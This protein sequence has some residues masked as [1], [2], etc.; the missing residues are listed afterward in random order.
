MTPGIPPI[1]RAPSKERGIPLTVNIP[2]H[3]GSL[4]PLPMSPVIAPNGHL[5]EGPLDDSDE[6]VSTPRLDK[7]KQ[8]AKEE[9][10]KPTPVLRRPS[11]ALDSEDEFLE[12][13]V[14]PEAV[15]SPTID[16]SVVGNHFHCVVILM[17]I[18]TGLVVGLR[19]RERFSV[20]VQF[21]S[22]L[23]KWR[24]STRARTC[25]R[26]LA[27]CPLRPKFR[28]NLLTMDVLAPG[29]YG[30]APSSQGCSG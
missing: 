17:L 1:V 26:R 5:H 9:P 20:K 12:P 10:A 8:R 25:G 15:I 19:K 7:G 6:E 21:S 11:S 23:R 18:E 16:R 28:S 4:S 2:S 30:R 14:H 24:E 27:S 29:S 22:A 3:D 13:G